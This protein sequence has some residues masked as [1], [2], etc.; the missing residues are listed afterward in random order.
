MSWL[1]Q[2]RPAPSPAPLCHPAF[3][4]EWGPA[5]RR[6]AV[7]QKPCRCPRQDALQVGVPWGAGGEG[8][9][10]WELASSNGQL[11]GHCLGLKSRF[12]LPGDP[13]ASAAPLGPRPCVGRC[14]LL[15]VPTVVP[16]RWEA[17][18]EEATGWRGEPVLL[19]TL[20]PE[21]APQGSVRLHAPQEGG[22]V[23]G[24]GPG[25]PPTQPCPHRL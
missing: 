18:G 25:S 6:A 7:T 21:P 22:G 13:T 24:W 9:A 12:P 19:E 10:P 1:V 15:P 5:T 11:S 17:E 8:G 20:S 23:H 2:A 14:A 3:L 4:S 16:A